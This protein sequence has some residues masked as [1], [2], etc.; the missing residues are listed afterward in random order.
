MENNMDLFERYLQAVRRYLP[1]ERQ[2]DI[3][4]E[5]RANLEAQR[6]EREADAGPAA[7]GRRDD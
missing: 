2:D 7:H 1:G 5:L 4:A 6:E 3:V